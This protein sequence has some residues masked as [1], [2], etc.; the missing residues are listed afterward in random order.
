M[1]WKVLVTARA[2]WVSG[3]ESLK[4]LE[5]AGCEVVR[6]PRPGPLPE[7]ELIE[8]L[9]GCQAVI[10]SSDPYNARVFAACPELKIVARCGVGTD[11]SIWRLRRRQGSSRP[12]LPAP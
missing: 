11:W 9:Q 1:G 10:A 3:Q 2:L 4:A 8:T 12:T 5:A 7:E 6:P